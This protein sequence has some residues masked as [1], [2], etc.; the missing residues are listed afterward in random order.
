MLTTKVDSILP[1]CWLDL[2]QVAVSLRGSF[3]PLIL[4]PKVEIAV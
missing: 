1:D 4:P 2:N 3:D